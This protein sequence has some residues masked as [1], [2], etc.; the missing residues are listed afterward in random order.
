MEA[1]GKAMAYT[2]YGG[3]PTTPMMKKSAPKAKAAPKKAAKT[4]FNPAK[5]ERAKKSVFGMK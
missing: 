4:A 1:G 3:N 2:S 5:F